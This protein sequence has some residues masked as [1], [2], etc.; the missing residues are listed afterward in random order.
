MIVLHETQIVNEKTD[1]GIENLTSVSLFLPCKSLFVSV[2]V[3]TFKNKIL[4]IQYVKNAEPVE[5]V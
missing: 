4:L 1:V 2:F 3:L 5:L